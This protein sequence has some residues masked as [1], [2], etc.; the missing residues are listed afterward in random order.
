MRV[1]CQPQG[2]SRRPFLTSQLTRRCSDNTQ[3]FGRLVCTHSRSS[4][5]GDRNVGLIQASRRFEGDDRIHK[6]IAM[7]SCFFSCLSFCFVMR[8]IATLSMGVKSL[9]MYHYHR[10]TIVTPTTDAV[11]KWFLSAFS[12][13]RTIV[14]HVIHVWTLLDVCFWIRQSFVYRHIAACNVFVSMS[15]KQ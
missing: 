15:N 6:T 7:F 11:K 10:W 2:L 4:H 9:H 1:L 13:T 14:T 12:Y 8:S 5:T 3:L